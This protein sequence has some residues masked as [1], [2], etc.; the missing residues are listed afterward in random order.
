MNTR[1]PL[2]SQVLGSKSNYVLG[3]S[4]TLVPPRTPAPLQC[5]GCQGVRYANAEEAHMCM[6]VT[7]S[8]PPILQ[9]KED[10]GAKLVQIAFKITMTVE[11][12][13]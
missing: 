13:L 10:D 8:S 12:I 7:F 6:C 9:S 4:Q 11:V 3:V 1:A 5:G 2:H